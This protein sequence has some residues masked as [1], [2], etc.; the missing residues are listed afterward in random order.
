MKIAVI[1]DIHANLLALEAV[2]EDIEKRLSVKE[3][4]KTQ[5]NEHVG[6]VNVNMRLKLYYNDD[7]C[8]IKIISRYGEGTTVRITFLKEPPISENHE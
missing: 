2:L 4:D 7:D 3:F 5:S 8:G 1:S 6:L